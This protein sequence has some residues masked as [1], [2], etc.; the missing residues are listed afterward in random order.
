[1]VGPLSLPALYIP[2]FLVLSA[3]Y[4]SFRRPRQ[5]ESVL[6]WWRAGFTGTLKRQTRDEEKPVNGSA[7]ASPACETAFPPSS[8]HRVSQVL[9]KQGINGT[10][11]A[12]LKISERDLQKQ[13]LPFESDFRVSEPSKYTPMGV[14]V[15][16]VKALGDFPDYSALSGVP[17]PEE[18]KDFRIETAIPRPYRPFRWPYHQTMCK[19]LR[20]GMP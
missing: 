2:I 15:A 14:S 6:K 20:S 17:Q 11:G 13:V 9:G 7:P 8:H 18:Y 3:L 10:T 16:E 4:F 12:S 5:L 19:Q 1:M